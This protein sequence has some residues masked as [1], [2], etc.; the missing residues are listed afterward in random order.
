MMVAFS[1]LFPSYILG[2]AP[3]VS[4][5]EVSRQ[6]IPAHKRLKQDAAEASFEVT[7]RQIEGGDI[8]ALDAPTDSVEIKQTVRIY[9]KR[10]FT[11]LEVLGGVPGAEI[12]PGLENNNIHTVLAVGPSHAYLYTPLPTS[13]NPFANLARLNPDDLRVRMLVDIFLNHLQALTTVAGHESSNFLTSPQLS[14]TTQ[15]SGDITLRTDGNE[16]GTAFDMEVTFAPAQQWAVKSY[17]VSTTSDEQGSTTQRAR[18]TSQSLKGK[19]LPLEIRIQSV[20]DELNN[21]EIITL[22]PLQDLKDT[23]LTEDFFRRYQRFYTVTGEDGKVEKTIDAVPPAFQA[24]YAERMGLR[25]NLSGQATGRIVLAC[26][27]FLGLA[28]A[29]WYLRKRK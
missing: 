25:K 3:P 24:N 29:T 5:S 10:D 28:G 19:L 18:I 12:A 26:C 20:S 27:V 4:L 16:E 13:A 8:R 14:I 22:K 23:K 11:V 7:V 21:V 1:A 6:L 17:T 2:Q 9:K 15:T